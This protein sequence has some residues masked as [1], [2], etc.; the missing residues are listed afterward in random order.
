MSVVPFVTVVVPTHDRPAALERCLAGLVQQDYPAGSFEL[1][2]VDDGSTRPV[3]VCAEVCARV[4][5]TVV[6]Q[7]QSGP[8]AARNV[9]VQHAV[10]SFIA[11]IDDDCVAERGWLAALVSTLTDHPGAGAGGHVLNGLATNA[12]S[13]ASQLL[14][15]FLY[16]YYNREPESARFLTS[17]NL[18][19]PRIGLVDVG[20][21]DP[22]Y[23][24]AAGEDRELCDRWTRLG[25]RLIYVPDARVSHAHPLTLRTFWRQH[26]TYGRGAWG[27][28]QSKARDGVRGVRVEPLTF[29]WGLITHPLRH[30]GPSG[31]RFSARLLFAQIANAIGFAAEAVRGRAGMHT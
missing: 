30:R 2:V 9:G 4:R 20:G 25:R 14:V 10:G 13:E 28:R 21:F 27:F 5:V 1:I 24:R 11:F 18:A 12:W 15:G 29:Y 3:T 22:V 23:Q 26:Y 31:A 19:F 6:R 16:G 8:A 17:N 7:N